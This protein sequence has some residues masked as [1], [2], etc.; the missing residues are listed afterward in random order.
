MRLAIIKLRGNEILMELYSLDGG[1]IRGYNETWEEARQN[2]RDA[3]YE[4]L[5]EG[6]RGE[7]HFEVWSIGIKGTG[8]E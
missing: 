7:S 2:L 6:G 4:F 5:F 1:Y 3:N 8:K